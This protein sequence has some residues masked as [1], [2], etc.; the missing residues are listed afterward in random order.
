M[1]KLLVD[2]EVVLDVVLDRRPHAAAAT[3]LWA[4][5]EERRVT[6]LIPAHR[7]TTAFYLLERRHGS[8]TA[9]KTIRLILQVFGVAG[10]DA[11][12][13]HRAASLQMIDF[14]DAVMVAA[15]EAA[16]CEAVVTR[17]LAGFSGSSLPAIAPDVALALLADEAR[18]PGP[19]T[20]R[21]QRQPS[22]PPT[23][24]PEA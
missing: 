18:A 4:A 21:R 12:V 14:E 1:R 13:L 22:Q 23:D 5:T 20:R 15:A 8:A 6:T 19:L 10:V 17:D 16:G 7:L 3:G 11:A 9:W 2:L 24:P